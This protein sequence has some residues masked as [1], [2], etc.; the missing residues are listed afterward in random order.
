MFRGLISGLFWGLIVS[1]LGLA[2]VSLMAD[3]S[4][5]V[6]NS[7]D[8]A[9][10]EGSEFNR[11]RPEAVPVIPGTEGNNTDGATPL[12][13][14]AEGEAAPVADTASAAV[15]NSGTQAL[16]G[17]A[18]PDTNSE[19][20]SVSLGDSGVQS[21]G[22][23]P[24][25]AS[26][27]PVD[28]DA[29]ETPAKPDPNLVPEGVTPEAEPEQ[30]VLD[31][32][33]PASPAVQLPE[34][35]QAATNSGGAEGVPS[36]PVTAIVPTETVAV[37]VTVEPAPAPVEQ[38]AQVAEVKPE[39][40]VQ[41]VTP[42]TGLTTRL[43]SIGDGDAELEASDEPP[44]EIVLEGDAEVD[45]SLGAMARNARPFT[46]T[47]DMP[48]M[49]IILIDV[50]AD[51]L[52]R[53]SLQT[54]SFPVTIA[55]DPFSADAQ[56][57]AAAFR[58]SGQEVLVSAGPMPEGIASDTI[59]DYLGTL[60]APIPQA[61]GLVDAAQGGFQSNRRLIDNAVSTLSN[62]GHALVTYDR[63][64]N[65]ALQSAAKRGV[66]AGAIYRT[67]DAE[68]E[69]AATIRRYLDRAAFKAGQE[70]QVIMI[71]HS[72]PETIKAV[73]FWVLDGKGSTVELAPL[74]ALL[75]Q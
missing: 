43:S 49:A 48:L 71:G 69:N 63:G 40:P 16:T 35:T 34:T 13:T 17:L 66:P 7:V 51:G 46:R 39:A 12:V 24:T 68:R 27:T 36:E 57:A 45:M 54:L 31:L 60:V 11:N 62:G 8:V 67:L 20:L 42:I 44:L 52:D 30:P 5:D 23:T 9:V 37:E 55:I 10:P 38:V 59:G 28:E 32:A 73:F 22:A 1:A 4:K 58:S 25:I 53:E 26:P 29:P 6:P 74:S 47:S 64:L 41:P 3:L 2:V 75:R 19:G 70:G 14:A 18:A 56:D 15:P 50:G 33:A 65:T 21:G 72:Y 61:I